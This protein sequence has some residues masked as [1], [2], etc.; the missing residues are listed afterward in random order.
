PGYGSARG[1]G[2]AEAGARP[3]RRL[4]R[5]GTDSDAAWQRRRGRAIAEQGARTRRHPLSGEREPGNALRQDEGSAP[6]RASRA[7]RDTAGA[8]R[9][10]GPGFPSGHRGGT[11]AARMWIAASRLALVSLLAGL[12]A[13][14]DSIIAAQTRPAA[15]PDTR[16]TQAT[17]ALSAGDLDRAS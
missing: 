3:R 2:G 5:V 11:V 9:H 16:L 8:A 12:L 13:A 14:S 15:A 1:R 7:D 17:R 10:P 6:R 4:V